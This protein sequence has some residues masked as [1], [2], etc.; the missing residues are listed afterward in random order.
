MTVDERTT[1]VT[2]ERRPGRPRIHDTPADRVRAHRERKRAEAAAA[3]LP[4]LPTADDPE[5]AVSA[6]VDVLP[7][8]R[9][10]AQGAAEKMAAIAAQ[11]TAAT[12]VLGDKPTLDAHLRRAQAEAEKV[13]A[14]ADADL[15]DLREQLDAALEDRANADAA[16]EAAD[17]EAAAAHAALETE[18]AAHA[19][20]AAAVAEQ[21]R[22]DRAQA[23][24]EHDRA[25]QKLKAEAVDAGIRHTAECDTL[26][27][28]ITAA[29]AERDAMEE[30]RDAARLSAERDAA[31][32]AA[33][34]ARLD[35]DLAA[36]KQAT[37]AE[38][39]RA[40]AARQELNAALIE[41][42]EAR[43][44]T[45]AARERAEELR[46]ERDGLRAPQ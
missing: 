34:I 3:V 30:Q 45:V 35:A 5:G 26:T 41:L 23:H 29:H 43:A 20:Q 13:R 28:Q 33:S 46:A 15:A 44:Q 10:E 40:D 16:A 25:V 32:T 7:R 17:T 9:Q 6:L 39:E 12:A 37:V 21:H 31:A 19:E 18:R 24:D 8:L 22:R 4:A 14:D 36:Q 1:T 11:I 27:A 2:D 38:R 42:A